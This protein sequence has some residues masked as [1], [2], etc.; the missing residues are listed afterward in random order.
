MKDSAQRARNRQSAEP[1]RPQEPVTSQ[2]RGGSKLAEER[3]SA[4]A[5]S[6][7]VQKQ[8]CE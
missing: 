2:I 6:A 1:P 3:G 4:G 5:L 7:S 8:S